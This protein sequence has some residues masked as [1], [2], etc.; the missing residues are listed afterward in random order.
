MKT[1]ESKIFKI[2]IS[3]I[4]IWFFLYFFGYQLGKFYYHITH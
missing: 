2:I 4:I 1:K 3:V